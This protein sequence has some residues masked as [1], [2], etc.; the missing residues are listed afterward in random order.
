M[1][2]EI[3]DKAL[4]PSSETIRGWLKTK[5]NKSQFQESGG[6]PNARTSSLKENV[7]R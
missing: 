1:E 6:V 7:F 4:T 5:T 2:G 3:K